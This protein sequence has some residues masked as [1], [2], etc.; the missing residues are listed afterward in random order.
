MNNENILYFD[1]LF[2]KFR[3]ITD[4]LQSVESTAKNLTKPVQLCVLPE[5]FKATY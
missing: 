5:L 2:R 3:L 4:I 1:P